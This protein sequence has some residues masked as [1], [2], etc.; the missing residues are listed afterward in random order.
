[1]ESPKMERLTALAKTRFLSLYD[2]EY[3][4]RKGEPK[5]WIIASRK[6]YEDLE[7]LYFNHGEEKTDAVVLVAIHQETHQLV[8][9]RQFRMP[10]NDFI[11]ELP[12]GLIDEGEDANSTIGRELREET[13]L[14]LI[15]VTHLQDKLYLS[16]GMTDESVALVYCTCKGAVSTE[17]LEADETIEPILVSKE[18]AQ[19]ILESGSKLDIKTYLVLQQFILGML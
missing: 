3:K 6:S 7:N 5:H 1:M 13:G 15:E 9:I 18:E 19:K 4:N 12:A 14:E 10:L 11:Y 16:A 8:L 2:A 17:Y